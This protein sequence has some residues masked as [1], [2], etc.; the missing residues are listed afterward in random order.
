[1]TARNRCAG[2]KTPGIVL[3]QK[4]NAVPEI[5]QEARHQRQAPNGVGRHADFRSGKERLLL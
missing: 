1:M 5:H 4:K 2:E 3:P